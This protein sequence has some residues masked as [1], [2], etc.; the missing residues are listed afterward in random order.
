MLAKHSEGACDQQ[1]HQS[2]LRPEIRK[3]V[4]CRKNNSKT[5][6]N[7]IITK[8]NTN[9]HLIVYIV[10]VALLLAEVQ[11]FAP[12]EF[13]NNKDVDGS[14]GEFFFAERGGIG[15][16]FQPFSPIW[17]GAE[18][19]TF[20]MTSHGFPLTQIPRSAV[21]YLNAT[22]PDLTINHALS[23]DTFAFDESIF[24]IDTS[25]GELQ[26]LIEEVDLPARNRLPF[27]KTETTINSNT[28]NES[29]GNWTCRSGMGSPYLNDTMFTQ[30]STRSVST[31]EINSIIGFARQKCDFMIGG[32]NSRTVVVMSRMLAHVPVLGYGATS[33]GLSDAELHPLFVRAVPA[34]VATVTFVA[35]FM[36]VMGWAGCY[37]VTDVQNPTSTCWEDISST[38]TAATSH[39]APIIFITTGDAYGSSVRSDMQRL[40]TTDYLSSTSEGGNSGNARWKSW[41]V[42]TFADLIIDSSNEERA[43][44]DMRNI[45]TILKE[46][47]H[48]KLIFLG[49]NFPGISGTEAIKIFGEAKLYETH[50]IVGLDSACLY[51]IPGLICPRST[52]DETEMKPYV[53]D[54]LHGLNGDLVKVVP[55]HPAGMVAPPYKYPFTYAEG[56]FALFAYLLDIVGIAMNATVELAREYLGCPTDPITGLV[57]T[58]NNRCTQAILDSV[59]NNPTDAG[60]ILAFGNQSASLLPRYAATKFHNSTSMEKIMNLLR[61]GTLQNP[62][63]IKPLFKANKRLPKP[64]KNR[65]RF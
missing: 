33:N 12:T 24:D 5:H 41:E 26:M 17:L 38:P 61:H 44:A 60:Q 62:I 14:R 51:D 63:S 43:I 39:L 18:A 40:L 54:P 65:Y 56:S 31:E 50:I 20:C 53:E 42:P 55:D 29:S 6:I 13:P 45:P 28:A 59:F 48:S 64:S 35:D 27:D 8:R 57:T 52:Y 1:R 23:F 9:L 16:V 11:P 30:A 32:G 7:S 19:V 4:S 2:T 49:V 10:V 37:S 3:A 58:N 36:K 21:I 47:P 46:Y 34:D 25:T 22:R 15:G